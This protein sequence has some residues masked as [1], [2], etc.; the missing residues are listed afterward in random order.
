MRR[1]RSCFQVILVAILCIALGSFLGC[2]PQKRYQVLSFFFDGVPVPGGAQ[3]GGG[4]EGGRPIAYTHKPYAEGKCGSC[5]ASDELE[6]TVDRPTNLTAISSSV[7]LKCHAKIPAEYSVMH[8]P[9]ASAQCLLCHAP[10]QSA[11]PHLLNA[12]AP[13][14]CVQCHAPETMI[15][16]RPE[17]QDEKADCL[18]C[19]SGHG[20]TA[21]GLLRANAPATTRPATQPAVSS[22]PDAGRETGL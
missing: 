20:G 17:H 8:G 16:R 19:H 7:C 5:H 18:S 3:G 15:P 9:V 22:L 14:L 10:H 12:P 11:V 2:S 4:G 1:A 21:H 6:M 13:R